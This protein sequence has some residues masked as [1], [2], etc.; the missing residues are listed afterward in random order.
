MSVAWKSLER[1]VAKELNGRRISRGLDFG[2]SVHDVEL[3]N[4]PE[5]KI[6]AKLRGSYKHHRLWE[7][8]QAKYCRQ[9][10]NIAILATRE[11]GKHRILVVLDIG[12]FRELLSAYLGGPDGT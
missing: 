8:V 7:E 4:C 1:R 9:P 3:P 2:L 6:D 10:K 12:F 5:L 11:K